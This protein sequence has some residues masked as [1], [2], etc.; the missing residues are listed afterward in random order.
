[1]DEVQDTRRLMTAKVE[2]TRRPARP[3][4]YG[5]EKMNKDT[6]CLGIKRVAAAGWGGR[7]GTLGL[8]KSCSAKIDDNDKDDTQS[9]E[10]NSGTVLPFVFSKTSQFI[11][12]T[13]PII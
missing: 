3:R 13:P 9:P 11:L 8:P 1:M 10:V 2:S 5:L 4:K 12:T 7:L 6:R